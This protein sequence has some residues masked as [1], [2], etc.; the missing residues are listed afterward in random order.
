MNKISEKIK[1]YITHLFKVPFIASNLRFSVFTF[2]KI[3]FS[4]I[5]SKVSAISMG[6]AGVGYFGTV[7]NFQNIAATL[8]SLGLGAGLSTELS[9]CIKKNDTAGIKRALGVAF[10]GLIT[11]TTAAIFIF[12]FLHDK[13]SQWIFD[14]DSF[15]S[16]LVPAIL[17]VPFF[18]ISTCYFEPILY[19]HSKDAGAAKAY[20]WGTILDLICFLPLVYFVGLSGASVSLFLSAFFL[21][22][23]L[24]LQI[25]KNCPHIQLFQFDFHYLTLREFL[26]T[27]SVMLG[28]GIAIYGVGI[29]IRSI[30]MRV[31]S[32]EANGYYQVSLALSAFYMPFVTN[33]IWVRLFPHAAGNGMNEAVAL[34]LSES[35]VYTA[36]FAATAQMFLM[37][38]PHLIIKILY[39][40]DFTP[41]ASIVPLRLFGDYFY[42]LSQPIICVFLA[43]KKRRLYI[44]TIFVTQFLFCILAFEMSKQGL[45]GLTAAYTISNLLVFLYCMKKYVGFLKNFS[46]LT[47]I[48]RRGLDLL[49]FFSFMLLIQLATSYFFQNIFIQLGIFLFFLSALYFIYKSRFFSDLLKIR[50]Q[51]KVDEK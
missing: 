34:E 45:V 12:F 11:S 9:Q 25:R 7:Q 17:S 50:L 5:R 20:Q 41:A 1:F 23:F 32:D 37:I 51:L 16:L 33:A 15:S 35:L 10:T 36:V 21:F 39:T 19:S 24:W 42:L 28:S 4:P 49:I 2:F 31:I 3:A 27:G 13:F 26:K 38:S 22:L 48:K 43:L 40:K 18:V 46:G 30:I 47:I 6:T 14:D 8:S 29:V 44:G